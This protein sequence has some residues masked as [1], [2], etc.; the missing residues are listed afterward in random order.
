MVRRLFGTTVFIVG[1]EKSDNGRSCVNHTVCGSTLTKAMEVCLRH[2]IVRIDDGEEEPAIAAHAVV[3]G[4]ETCRVGFLSKEVAYRDSIEKKYDGLHAAVLDVFCR[5][6]AKT[7]SP[8]HR[9][10][11]RENYG[12]AQALI[13]TP[14]SLKRQVNEEPGSVRHKKSKQSH[15]QTDS[16]VQLEEESGSI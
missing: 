7:I 4:I 14:D 8:F 11:V 9:R 5:D 13:T 12:C 16:D 15:E 10:L 1:L 3:D 6:K 2:C